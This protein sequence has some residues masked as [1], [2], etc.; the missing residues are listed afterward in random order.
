[1]L[2]ARGLIGGALQLSLLASLL[3]I[4]AG[5]WDWPRAI[6]FLAVYGVVLFGSIVWLAVAAPSSLEARLSQLSAG[7]SRSPTASQRR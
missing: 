2:I 4:P 1:M 6:R 5:T 7:S 3:L